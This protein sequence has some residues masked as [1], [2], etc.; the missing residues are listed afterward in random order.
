MVTGTARITN[1]SVEDG[2]LTLSIRAKVDSIQLSSD[3]VGESSEPYPPALAPADSV[4]GKSDQADVARPIHDAGEGA[5]LEDVPD[6]AALRLDQLEDLDERP[7]L[8]PT[9]PT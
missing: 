5:H 3:G 9:A 2:Y 7:A 8:P 1:L 6:K 4:D